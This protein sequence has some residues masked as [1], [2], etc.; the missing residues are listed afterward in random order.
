MSSKFIPFFYDEFS[1]NHVLSYFLYDAEFCILEK[2][3]FCNSLLFKQ[4]RKDMFSQLYQSCNFCISH[5]CY[6]VIYV[7]FSFIFG[8][9]Y[10]YLRIL[11]MKNNSKIIR[12]VCRNT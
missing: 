10:V 6:V 7:V 8:V 9:V 4:T 2:G 11:V 5:P 1:V 12:N 3:I